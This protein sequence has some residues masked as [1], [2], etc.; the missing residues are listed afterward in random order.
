MFKLICITNRKMCGDFSERVSELYK[1]GIDVI[2]REKDLNEAEYEKLAK[3]VIEVC[4]DVILHTYTDAAERLGIKKIHLPFAML[5]PDMDFKTVGVSVHSAAEA[6][7][8]EKMGADYVI[9][10]HIFATDCK[11]GLEPRG[12]DF[13]RE[14]VNA[15]NIP[16]YAVGGIMPNNIGMI[17][18]TGAQ[19]ACIMSGF[20]Q[21]AS[22]NGY[23]K[24][25]IN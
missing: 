6:K 16:V 19:G 13:L 10:G 24:K 2:L 15:V 12:T 25:F 3:K 7:A 20:M 11:K 5:K 18:G 4:P 8:A 9:A 17:K 1:N 23:I 22:V 14:V 21:C